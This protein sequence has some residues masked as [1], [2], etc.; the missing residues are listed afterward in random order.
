[1]AVALDAIVCPAWGI[2]ANTPRNN[3]LLIQCIHG[4]RL[5]GAIKATTTTVDCGNGTR[6]RT[7]QLN[8]QSPPSVPGMQLHVNPAKLSYRVT[9]PLED[10]D[11]AKKGLEDYF[12]TATGVKQKIKAV[13]AYGGTLD[14]DRMKALCRE[15]LRIVEAG[16][17]V[18]VKGGK[19]TLESIDNLDGNYLLNPGAQVHNSQPRHEK[20]L[21]A[22]EQ[23]LAAS[24]G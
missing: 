5:R 15:M 3:D 21:A 12:R 7:P 24:G 6:V 8:Q 22:W 4:L 17:A 14:A 13:P 1:M 9:D 2:E 19:P 20:D 18:V 11:A 10:D 16:D 23:R